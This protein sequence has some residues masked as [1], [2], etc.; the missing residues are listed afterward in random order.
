MTEPTI[1]PLDR[2][3]DERGW[4]SEIYSGELGEDLRNIHLGTMTPGTVRGNHRHERTR[5]WITF[6]GTPIT[7]RWGDPGESYETV[8]EEPATVQLP[9][10]LPHAFK[11]TGSA[12]VSFVAYTNTLYEEE[13]PD[14]VP[15]ELFD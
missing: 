15:V 5:E 10:S 13:N 1:T 4:V 14:V 8:L 3:R 6:L 9:V 7:V 11:N 2:H 12:T